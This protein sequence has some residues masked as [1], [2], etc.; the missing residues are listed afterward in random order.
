MPKRKVL[1]VKNLFLTGLIFLTGCSSIFDSHAR[2][3]S[4]NSVSPNSRWGEQYPSDHFPQTGIASWYGPTF[5]GKPTASGDIFRK[6][7]LTAAHRTLPLGTRVRV[8]NLRNNKEVDV[9]VNDRGPFVE[10][11]VIDLSWLAAKQIGLLQTGTAPVRITP[12]NRLFV[13]ENTRHTFYVIQ[14]GTFTRK[15]DAQRFLNGLTQ[16]HHRQ[17]VASQYNGGRVYR[18]RIGSY[19]SIADARKSADQVKKR[20]GEAFIVK[21]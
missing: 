13:D 9:L 19:S 16:Y 17:L 18:V 2:W 14:V 3:G 5:Y 6:N 1:S 15:V 20:L 7:G 10:G 4:R 11:R 12:L 8:R 21:Q